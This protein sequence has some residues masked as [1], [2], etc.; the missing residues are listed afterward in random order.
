[1]TCMPTAAEDA[2]AAAPVLE[3]RGIEKRYGGIRALRGADLVIE[4]PGVVHGLIGQNGSG[5]STLLGVLSGQVRPDAGAI[6]LG[7]DTVNLR[8]PQAALQHGIAMVSQE[9]AVAPHL[10]VAENIL[11]GRGL[12]RGRFGISWK[13]TRERSLEYL[14]RL[15]LDYDPAW[16]VSRLRPDQRQMVEIARALSSDA[17]I[18]ILDEPTSSLTDDEV[19]GLF[20]AVENLK[21][22][23]VSTIY[24]SHRM[25]EIFE[26]TDELTILRD[27]LTV[28]R[29]PVEDFTPGGLIEA[30]VGRSGVRD[31]AARAEGSSVR[32]RT[33][34]L[35][36]R[37]LTVDGCVAEVDLDVHAGEIVGLAGL[38]GAGRS[39]LL[40]AIFGVRARSAGTVAMRGDAQLRVG[41]RPS[42]AAGIGFLPPD[43]TRQG[44][45]LHRSVTENLMMVTTSGQGRLR[46]PRRAQEAA[47]VAEA[48]ASMGIRAHSA[49]VAV[50]T[51]SGGNQQKVALGKWLAADSEVLLLDEPTRG[52]DVASKVEIH[53]LLRD[54]ADRGLGLLISSSETPELIAL[55][56]R[57][58][59]MFRGRIVASLPGAEATEALVA[60][61]AGGH[62]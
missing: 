38:V 41:P 42:I 55:C 58:L 27:G 30:M 57:I 50:G 17:R 11:L 25:S 33:P 28:D 7:G 54:A 19:E 3:M 21:R 43:R 18:I 23:G 14:E 53:E 62:A 49:D 56:H 46:A 4:R 8:N 24:V 37:G 48:S 15:E 47:A 1:M 51:L 32:A 34:L 61:H 59:V 35:S 36:V 13:R 40:E 52:V 2:T 45:V 22:Q 26:L 6:A 29:G 20:K 31:I 44:L 39:E 12:V 9:T 60:H 16:T 5:K 10:T